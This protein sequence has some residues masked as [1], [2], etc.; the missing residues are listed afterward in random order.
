MVNM[1]SAG[2]IMIALFIGLIIAVV[3]L[4]SSAD[5]VSLQ[6]STFSVVNESVTA[7]VVGTPLALTGKVL[8]GDGVIY[9]GT[10]IEIIGASNMTITDGISGA[11]SFCFSITPW[12]RPN[13]IGISLDP[14]I[15]EY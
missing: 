12:P 8:I 1:K 13:L 14:S 3:F 10:S 11:L 6:T 15:T 5:T 2:G 9:N 4:D 7:P